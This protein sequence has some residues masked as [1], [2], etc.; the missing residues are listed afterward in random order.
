MKRITI[1]IFGFGVICECPTSELA[2]KIEKDFHYF[3]ERSLTGCKKILTLKLFTEI[4][5]TVIPRNIVVTKQTENSLY[6]DERHIRYNDYYGEAIS[7]FNY[8]TETCD[9]YC[10]DLNFAHEL[11]YLI[12]LS[13]S[14]RYMDQNGWHKIHASAV[15]RNNKN[16]ILMMPSKGGKTTQLCYLL[17]DQGLDLVSDDTPVV[18]SKGQI[19]PFPLRIG[20]ENKDHIKKFFP[21]VDHDDLVSF[22]RKKY[23]QKYLISCQLL[24]NKVKAG[25]QNILVAGIRSTHL[26]PKIKKISKFKMFK[27]TL[28]HM[29]V[30][31]GLPTIVEYF[32]RTGLKEHIS[33]IKIFI[34]R[35][36]AALKLISHAQN[37]LFI[38]SSDFEANTELLKS[39][40]DER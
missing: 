13:R 32:L 38:A 11:I 22:Q 25:Q 17:Q 27:Y 29:V 19:H 8:Q 40:F 7:V 21:Y 26:K 37:Y 35:A 5:E 24:K 30:G 9:L 15:H 33:N 4:N 6:Y 12:I 18:D 23:S 34:S 36:W 28:E 20:L 2:I 10:P 39:L 1:N 31:I 14:G 16:L 3:L